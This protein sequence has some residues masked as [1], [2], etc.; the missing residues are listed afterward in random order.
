ML[1]LSREQLD[2]FTSQHLAMTAGPR[3]GFRYLTTARG[4]ADDFQIG[5]THDDLE[6]GTDDMKVRRPM[7][8][9][10][11]SH[12]YRAKSLQRRHGALVSNR[13]HTLHFKGAGSNSGG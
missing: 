4:L 5:D 6:I 9:R 13:V 7:I 1:T 3:Q 8:V 11:H 12:R 2:P 10:V